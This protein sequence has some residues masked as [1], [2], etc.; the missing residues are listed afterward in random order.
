MTLFTKIPNK[1]ATLDSTKGPCIEARE[2]QHSHAH[3]EA[4]RKSAS[5]LLGVNCAWVEEEEAPRKTI[6]LFTCHMTQQSSTSLT[7]RPPRQSWTFRSVRIGA[8]ETRLDADGQD[9]AVCPGCEWRLPLWRVNHALAMN[10]K[11]FINLMQT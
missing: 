2:G 11:D 1:Q 4:I 9:S 8:Q 6:V 7:R 10:K 5:E 3:I